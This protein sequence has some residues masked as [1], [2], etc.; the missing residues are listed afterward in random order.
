MNRLEKILLAI[1]ILIVILSYL[2]APFIFFQQDEWLM[3]GR[4]FTSNLL[5]FTFPKTLIGEG[6][7][8]I[9]VGNFIKFLAFQAFGFN[10][11]FYNLV[12]LLIHLLNS[13]L[14]FL[15]AKKLVKQKKFAVLA[16]LIFLCSPAA[17]E[18]VFW[19]IASLNMITLTLVLLS[20]LLIYSSSNLIFSA[21][22]LIISMLVIEY[23]LGS[24]L[25]IPIAILITRKEKL[26]KKIKLLIPFL[27]LDFIYLILREYLSISTRVVGPSANIHYLSYFKQMVVLPFKYLGQLLGLFQLESLLN[28]K[29]GVSDG[30]Q[31]VIIGFLMTIV[32]LST[33]FFYGKRHVTFS[34]NLFISLLFIATS[35]L[36]YL[37]IPTSGLLP[38]RY[39]IFGVAG[40][41]LLLMVIAD[42]LYQAKRQDLRIIIWILVISFALIG[43][44]SNYQKLDILYNVS[45]Q[46]QQILKSILMSEPKLPPKIIFYTE[47]DSSYYGLP[48]KVHLLPFQSGFGQTL[49]VW[50]QP[51]SKLPDEFFNDK[52]LWQIEDQGYQEFNGRGFGYFRNFSDLAEKIVDQKLSPSL[53]KAFA[54]DSTTGNL[55]DITEEIQGRL[56][57]YL[58]DKKQIGTSEFEL[59]TP[60]NQ[61]DL[62]KAVDGNR[63][64][65]WDSM[66][67]YGHPQFIDINFSQ[68]KRVA[69]ITIDTYNDLNQNQVG[70]KILLSNDGNNWQT[71]FYSKRYPPDD[72]GL[73]S[74]Y[75]KPQP[76]KYVRIEQV[77]YHCCADWIVH[78]LNIYE[79][80]D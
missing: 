37:F 62:G 3:F 13:Y 28:I 7:H 46:R 74:L 8:L 36:P 43:A 32:L 40:F 68:P 48:E 26:V 45:Q 5:T 51:K 52:F 4:A 1:L 57:G 70:F 63:E 30:Q 55:T 42:Q 19:P 22:L 59:I 18:I 14:V 9:P 56:A 61:A 25:F 60:N 29:L 33:I 75:L 41:A 34:K 58:A 38:G 50:Y 6:I 47:S 49:M 77:G 17:S 53:V 69:E 21:A 67:T 39:L 72:R 64:T 35:A 76:A 54:F 24:L 44:L 65:A 71:Y 11:I 79:A 10:Y 27:V 12:G 2:K 16:S 73:I 80:T 66:L 31:A 23:S 15:I 78:E 20:W